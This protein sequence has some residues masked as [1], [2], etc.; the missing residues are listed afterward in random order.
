[1]IFRNTSSNFIQLRSA[2]NTVDKTVDIKQVQKNLIYVLLH[3]R[4]LKFWSSPN[5]NVNNYSGRLAIFSTKQT[6]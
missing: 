3:V 1:M 2:D 4:K 5:K 6:C